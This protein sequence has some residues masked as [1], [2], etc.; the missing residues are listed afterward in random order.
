MTIRTTTCIG[1]VALLS[2]IFLLQACGS[3]NP[4]T[5]SAGG[6]PASTGGTVANGGSVAPATGGIVATGGSTTA[7]NTGG[8]TVAPATG[9]TASAGGTTV[10]P[11]TGGAIGAGGTT[12]APATGGVVGT[13]GTTIVP[14]T[15][16][17]MGSGG[18]AGTG[19]AG[20]SNPVDASGTYQPLCKGLA[21]AAGPEP[22]KGGICADSDPQ[23]C[24][25]TCGPKSIGFKS[26]TCAGGSYS[27][28]TGCDFPPSLD[29][30]CFKIPAT[31]DPTC[32]ATAPQ[33]S[34]PCTVAD[35][36]PCNV[37]GNYSDSG[38]QS[39]A[40]Y[41]VCPSPSSAT[42]TSKWTCASTSAWPCPNG[43]G[44]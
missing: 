32:P 21:T 9:G 28:Q 7:S 33:A 30:S 35:C 8:A 26:E 44:C 17:T 22:T 10:A 1:T 39:K 14:V 2:Q 24:Y 38:G 13:G 19:D 16:G 37:G 15:G 3:N 27:E 6:S 40:G 42:A 43:Q 18:K 41:C 25:K 4:S 20:T 36:V 34:Q 11:A 5:V 31:I 29:Y 23:L 12:A